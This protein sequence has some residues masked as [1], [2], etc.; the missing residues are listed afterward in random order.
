MMREWVGSLEVLFLYSVCVFELI[1]VCGAIL[2]LQRGFIVEEVCY[3]IA[4]K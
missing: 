1:P 4:V 2:L 3:P